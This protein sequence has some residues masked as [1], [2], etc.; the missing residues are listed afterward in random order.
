MDS[1]RRTATWTPVS[2]SIALSSAADILVILQM[3]PI[4]TTLFFVFQPQLRNHQCKAIKA[5]PVLKALL[6]SPNVT[7]SPVKELFFWP[8]FVAAEPSQVRQAFFFFFVFQSQLDDHQSDPQHRG[9]ILKPFSDT[10]KG[11]S[12]REYSIDFWFPKLS[13]KLFRLAQIATT[14]LFIF[15]PQLENH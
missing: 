1:N 5:W 10:P 15:P 4:S 12:S 7:H 3:A 8:A 2:E 14:L 6:D 9:R 11:H 13:T